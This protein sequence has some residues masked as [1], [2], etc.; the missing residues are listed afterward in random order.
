MKNL[1]SIGRRLWTTLIMV[2]FLT[3]CLDQEHIA[4]NDAIKLEIEK[5]AHLNCGGFSSGE[6]GYVDENSIFHDYGS[7]N[8]VL[9]IESLKVTFDPS[10]VYEH[11]AFMNFTTPDELARELLD[12]TLKKVDG[13]SMKFLRSI[14]GSLRSIVLHN[15]L[16]FPYL[17]SRFSRWLW[18]DEEQVRNDAIYK[19][20]LGAE[21]QDS[22]WLAFKNLGEIQ[23]LTFIYELELTSDRNRISSRVN[24]NCRI[25]R[26]IL[27]NDKR[28][29]S[30][31]K[32]VDGLEKGSVYTDISI[33]NEFDYSVELEFITTK[34]SRHSRRIEYSLGPR[35]I[36]IMTGYP[37]IHIEDYPHFNKDIV[38]LKIS[39]RNGCNLYF[40]REQLAPF[41]KTFSRT[42][43]KKRHYETREGYEVSL[44]KICS[45][46][47]NNV[48]RKTL[49]SS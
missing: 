23:G 12:D 37:G 26:N 42:E 15:L 44:K 28:W 8:D 49:P 39:S 3:S 48:E 38:S 9:P 19:I 5:I 4:E 6:T 43:K 46:S 31:L 45:S 16:V 10:I 7:N 36:S 27:S 22:W 13:Y 17:D 29:L 47:S 30:L 41:I 33:N 1:L 14:D 21:T 20:L 2:L 18:S 34:E 24:L 25:V 35:E 40:T 32:Y 11:R